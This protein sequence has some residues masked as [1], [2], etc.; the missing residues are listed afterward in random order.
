MQIKSIQNACLSK[1]L[2]KRY[3]YGRGKYRKVA[4]KGV[5]SVL[6]YE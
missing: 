5:C 4:S 2:T 3:N 6:K 1:T